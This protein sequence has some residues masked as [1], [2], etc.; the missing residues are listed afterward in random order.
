MSK[1][2]PQ[3]IVSLIDGLVESDA[4]MGSI[5]DKQ[6]ITALELVNR[7]KSHGIAPPDGWVLVKRDN[8]LLEDIE[9]LLSQ[10][11]SAEC[12]NAAFPVKSL[13]RVLESCKAMLAAAPEVKP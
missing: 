8:E 3:E 9:F 12:C 10:K 4:C 1:V 6:V 5:S 7:I 11:M 2:T 13:T